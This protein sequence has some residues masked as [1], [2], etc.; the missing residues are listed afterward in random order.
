WLLEMCTTAGLCAAARLDGVDDV[1]RALLP[2]DG[3]VA[4]MDGTCA[5]L[6]AVSHYLGLLAEAGGRRND[7]VRHLEAAVEL[8]DHISAVPW[9][10]RSRLHLAPLL[11]DAD[12][13]SVLLEEALGMAEQHDLVASTRRIRAL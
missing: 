2:F 3:L 7:A 11:E 13:A 10:V 12:R 5:C 8:N 1:Y 6:G 9:A 4:T